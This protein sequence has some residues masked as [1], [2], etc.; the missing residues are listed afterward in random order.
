MPKASYLSAPPKLQIKFIRRVS[1]KNEFVAY[2]D[3]IGKLDGTRCLI[4]WKTTS[5]RYPEE[6]NGLL[7]LDPQLV[8]YSWMT[9]ISEI[10]DNSAV[11]PAPTP[12]RT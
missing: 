2:V 10:T 11:S 4:E 12:S 8:C 7:S 5:A 9:G 3:A 6:P 1:E